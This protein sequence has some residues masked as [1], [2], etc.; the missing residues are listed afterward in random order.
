MILSK[1]SNNP[2]MRIVMKKDSFICTI[3]TLDEEYVLSPS[4]LHIEA[5]AS[6]P[7]SFFSRDANLALIECH[8]PT[9]LSLRACHQSI[10]SCL[11]F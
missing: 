6:F 4:E 11:L 10:I 1:P 5:R 2:N 9:G 7:L 8:I 3:D